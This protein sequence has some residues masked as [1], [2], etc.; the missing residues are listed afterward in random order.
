MRSLC[1][2]L[3]LL[4]LKLLSYNYNIIVKAKNV[5]NNFIRNA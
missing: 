1:Q 5:L 2:K 3:E 4:H